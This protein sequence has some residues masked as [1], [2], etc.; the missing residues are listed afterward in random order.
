MMILLLGAEV[1]AVYAQEV[2]S[3]KRAH[4]KRAASAHPATDAAASSGSPLARSK[5]R[6]RAERVRKAGQKN[7]SGGRG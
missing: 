6:N 1:S 2:E 7:G 5:E 4:L 3:A